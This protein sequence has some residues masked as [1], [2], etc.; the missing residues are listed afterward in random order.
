[1]SDLIRLRASSAPMAFRCPGSVRRDGLL[2][3]EPNDAAT[4]GTAAHEALRDLAELGAVKWDALP[5]LAERFNVPL[6]ELRILCAQ[7]TKLWEEVKESFPEALTE[8]YLEAE[9]AP[10]RWLSG[11]LDLLSQQDRVAR[12][13]D[14]KTGRKDADH[15]H[16]VMAYAALL[17]LDNP[18]LEEV[19][20]TLLWV[21]DA[22]IENYTIT[23]AQFQ[24]WMREL[25]AEVFRWDGVYHPGS[26][27]LYCPRSATCEAANALARR[28]VAALRD[29]DIVSRAETALSEMSADEVVD[30]FEKASTVEKYAQRVREAIK[31]HVVKCGDVEANGKRLTLQT[32]ERRSV[33]PELAWP[34]LEA[35]GFEDGDFAAAMTLSASKCEKVVAKKAGRGKGAAAVRK[36]K[37]DLEAAGAIEIKETKKL[38]SRRA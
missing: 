12:F 15:R 20:G 2:V 19:T 36:L 22:E 3:D 32:E 34:V 25:D 11:H 1:M 21:R 8:V 31:A 17:F 9:V 5:E 29:T 30:I 18:Q 37:A 26:Q 33:D 14:W 10:G 27:C 16:Q 4:A 38:V 7:G 23:R 13:G 24:Q 28:D 35:A 6:E